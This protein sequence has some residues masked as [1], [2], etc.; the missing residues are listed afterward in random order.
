MEV[1]A[2]MKTLLISLIGAFAGA[3]L[4]ALFSIRIFG[5]SSGWMYIVFIIALAILGAR[6]ARKIYMKATKEE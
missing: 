1:V 6:I 5:I 2:S 3:M 4:A